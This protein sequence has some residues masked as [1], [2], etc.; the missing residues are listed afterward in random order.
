MQITQP[1]IIMG[2]HFWRLCQTLKEQWTTSLIGPPAIIL[3]QIP[4]NV[5]YFYHRLTIFNYF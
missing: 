4:L 2:T 5:I 3:K 1:H